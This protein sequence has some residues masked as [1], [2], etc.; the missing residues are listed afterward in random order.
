M[1][2]SSESPFLKPTPFEY[3]DLYR[4]GMGTENVGPLLRALVQMLRPNRVLEVGAGYTTPFLL[5][6]LVNNKRIFHDNNLDL[7]YIA[8][9]KYEPKLVVIDDMS[10]GE[11]AIKPGM[12]DIIDSEYV[13]FVEGK[14]QGKADQ[15]YNQYGNFDFVWYD[16]GDTDDYK[17]FINEYWK[18][19]S[20]YVLFHYTYS[21]GKPNVNLSVIIGETTGNP[22]RFD[23]VEPH[24]KSQGSVTIL[25]KA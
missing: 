21:D 1:M 14:F 9:H 12:K 20:N 17:V 18:I 11:L 13:D 15:L 23:I 16:C 24:K 3:P 25:K 7:E 10:L 2:G 8:G 19:C 22:A 5:E 4:P 6:G